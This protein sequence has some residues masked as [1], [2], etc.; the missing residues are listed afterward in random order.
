M[1]RQPAI[2][3]LLDRW[4]WHTFDDHSLL[5]RKL[6]EGGFLSRLADGSRYCRHPDRSTLDVTWGDEA[7]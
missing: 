2:E 4:A 3:R 7:R 5:R 6:C 1:K